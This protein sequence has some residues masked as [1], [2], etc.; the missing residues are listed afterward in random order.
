M[1]TT[2]LGTVGNVANAIALQSDGKIIIAGDTG[3]SSEFAV[4]RYTTNGILDTTFNG[5]GKVAIDFGSGLNQATAVQVQPD[6]KIV[7]AGYAVIGGTA[8]NMVAVRLQTNGVGDSSFGIFGEV[9]AQ[10]GSP[11]C[12]GTAMAIQSDGKI[13]IAGYS[14]NN[15]A[16]DFALVRYTTNGVPDHS[17][18]GNGQV[19]TSISLGQD[20]G[21][22]VG[23][24]PD[25]KIIMGG[26]ANILGH[27]Q[28]VAVRYN[29]NG[30]PDTTYGLNGFGF[31]NFGDAGDNNLN[32]LAIDSAGRVI[33]AGQ[34][35]GIFGIARLQ[36]DSRIIIQSLTC[37]ANGHAMMAG[38]GAP[39]T[40]YEVQTSTNL[41]LGSFG[42]LGAVTTDQNGNWEYEDSTATNAPARFYRLAHD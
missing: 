23:L 20:L 11:G 28:Y 19:V 37:L 5:T 40:Q 12:L 41:L 34:A 26:S 6:G 33:V 18:N 7:A 16:I 30:S 4:L 3:F 14:A 32:A 38:I 15:G 8:I 17:F 10:I 27:P 21:A 22:A 2:S 39:G 24:Q 25:G 42:N 9:A 36:A 29:T 35:A 13:L 1:V 31:V